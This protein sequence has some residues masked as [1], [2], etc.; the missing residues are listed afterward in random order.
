MTYTENV[1]ANIAKT[2][3]RLY[4]QTEFAVR[5]KEQLQRKLTIKFSNNKSNIVNHF[6]WKIIFNCT[7]NRYN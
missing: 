1:Q 7:S 6:H 5:K 2:T 4:K 3:D